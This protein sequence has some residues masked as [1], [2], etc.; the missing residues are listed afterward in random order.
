[1]A[2]EAILRVRLDNPIDFTIADAPSTPV[3]KGTVCQ[4]TDPVTA[5]AS[6]ADGNL[7]AGIAAREKVASDGRTRL[8]CFRRGIFD[9]VT[10]GTITIGQ[11]VTIGGANIVKAVAAG[12]AE[13]GAV[14]GQALEAASGGEVIQVLVGSS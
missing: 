2:N 8:A 11:L 13:S 14:V 3:L 12:E 6:A 7:F 5:S 9:M 10:T 1:M 4:L